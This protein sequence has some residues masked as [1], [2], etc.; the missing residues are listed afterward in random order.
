M[1]ALKSGQVPV[2]GG[3]KGIR[4]AGPPIR[5]P[6]PPTRRGAEAPPGAGGRGERRSGKS[7]GRRSTPP[8]PPRTSARASMPG[9][10]P[11]AGSRSPRR[12]T[13][14]GARRPRPGRPLRNPRPGRLISVHLREGQVETSKYIEI[15]QID[16]LIFTR[17]IPPAPRAWPESPGRRFAAALPWDS[18]PRVAQELGFRW[19][20]SPWKISNSPKAGGPGD[21]WVRL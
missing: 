2:A 11:L 4:L 7:C 3:R 9:S 21:F 15:F 5:P 19:R 17:E 8:L 14:R 20:Q 12:F 1:I 13:G 18:A 16:D 10:Q 6:D